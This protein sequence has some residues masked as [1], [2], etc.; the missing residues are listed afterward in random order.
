MRKSMGVWHM[1]KSMGVWH[2]RKSMGVW[3][4]RKS[5]VGDFLIPDEGVGTPVAQEAA[6]CQRTLRGSKLQVDARA[7][8]LELEAFDG[9]IN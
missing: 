9:L 1:R 2:M 4:M 8:V 7:E 5:M 3:H 6:N